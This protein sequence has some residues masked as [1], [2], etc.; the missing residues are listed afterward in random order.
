MTSV[1]IADEIT[2]G[3][4]ICYQLKPNMW[5]SCYPKDILLSI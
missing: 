5:I 2:I 4:H 3:T 1:S